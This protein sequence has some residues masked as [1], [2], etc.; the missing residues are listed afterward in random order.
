MVMVGLA[1]KLSAVPFHFW[2]PDVFEGASAEVG[3]FLS[4]AS[5]A[6]ALGLLMRLA[7]GFGYLGPAAAEQM[8]PTA[9]VYGDGPSFRGGNNVARADVTQTKE[10]YCSENGTIPFSRTAQS[11]QVLF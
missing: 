2:A 4:V 10:L 5:K 3:A 8:V 7:M 11:D 6:A 1:F 9:T